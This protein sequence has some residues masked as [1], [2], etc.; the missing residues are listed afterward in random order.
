MARMLVWA[1]S[2]RKMIAKTAS[3]LTACKTLVGR[4]QLQSAPPPSPFFLDK[5]APVFHFGYPGVAFPGDF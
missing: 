3:V 2:S 1:A 4:Q 5:K